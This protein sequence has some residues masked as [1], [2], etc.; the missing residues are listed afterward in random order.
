LTPGATAIA[1]NSIAIG[2]T[3]S[4]NNFA[5]VVI[6]T[7]VTGTLGDTPNNPEGMSVVIGYNASNNPFRRVGVSIGSNL[8]GFNGGLNIGSNNNCT[9]DGSS[10]FGHNNNSSNDSS[11]AQ[12]YGS[13]VHSA[14]SVALGGFNTISAGGVTS[15]VAGAEH[16]VSNK[17]STIGQAN[18][19][20]GER[21][22]AFGQSN[23]VTHDRAYV[24]GNNKSSVVADHLHV[25]GLFIYSA[26][27][28]SDNSSAISGGLVAGQIYKTS[29]G[30]LKIVY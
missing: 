17:S 24:F 10:A 20:S 23:V 27:T 6:G 12:G 4:T 8:N 7:K 14:Y 29:T 9:G 5:D 13:S 15:F 18:N 21:S 25:D 11:F 30:D 3:A 1:N 2:S 26:A 16:V 19:V 28:F 22:F